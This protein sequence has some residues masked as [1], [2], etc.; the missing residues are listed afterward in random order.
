MPK[1]FIVDDEPD[2]CFALQLF[3][4]QKGYKTQTF[5][6]AAGVLDS[7]LTEQPNVILLDVNLG[8]Y[9]GR[10][11]CKEIKQAADF[12]VGIILFSANEANL[13]QYKGYGADDVFSKPFDL[14]T[15]AEK[16]KENVAT[17]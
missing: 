13:L 4:N 17:R 16:I 12:A 9:D 15:V 14:N 7:V 11:L 3:L 1:V 2:I 10:V 6:S 8:N 5:V